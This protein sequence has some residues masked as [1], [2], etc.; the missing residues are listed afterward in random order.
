MRGRCR[1]CGLGGNWKA[2]LG[3]SENIPE[4]RFFMSDVPYEFVGGKKLAGNWES[5]SLGIVNSSIFVDQFGVRVSDS[6]AWSGDFGDNCGNWTSASSK[7]RGIAK[8]TSGNWDRTRKVGC[9]EELHLICFEQPLEGFID[10]CTEISGGN[11]NYWL[12]RDLS[13]EGNCLVVNASNI[14]LHGL[15]REIRGKGAAD[16]VGILVESSEGVFINSLDVKEFGDGILLKKVSGSGIQNVNSSFNRQ[17]IV[18]EQSDF[19]FVNNSFADFNSKAGIVLESSDLNIVEGVSCLSNDYSGII[20]SA[21]FNNIL[22]RAVVSKNS[23]YGLLVSY[24]GKNSVS[25]SD[26]SGNDFYGVSISGSDDNIF[27]ENSVLRNLNDGLILI[28]NSEGN[29]IRSNLLAENGRY[30]SSLSWSS[31]NSFVENEIGKNN[32]AAIGVSSFS[33]NNEFI[34]NFDG[35]FSNLRFGIYPQLNLLGNRYVNNSFQN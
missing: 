5:L 9:D 29:M 8:G 3:D 24:G 1:E 31:G 13:G 21:S 20:F 19:N 6:L 18:L 35:N 34:G 23:F 4:E 27:E 11:A 15:G 26:F 7:M 22:R 32:Y 25:N 28:R 14:S 12:G 16:S 10:R 2:Y 33:S 30:G 17:G